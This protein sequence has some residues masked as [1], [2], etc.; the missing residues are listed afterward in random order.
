MF[1]DNNGM[2]SEITDRRKFEKFINMW[3]L[4]KS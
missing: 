4:T 3:K 2:K 1:C